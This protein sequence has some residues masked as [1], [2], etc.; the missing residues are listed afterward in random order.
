MAIQRTRFRKYSKYGAVLVEDWNSD[1]FHSISEWRRWRVLK[2]REEKDIISELRC[3]VEFCL[4]DD[5]IPEDDRHYYIADFV[6]YDRDGNM[7]VEDVKNPALA[8][9]TKWYK[10]NKE[11]LTRYGLKVRLIHPY[12]V[13]VV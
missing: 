2:D 12:R 4:S 3:Q 10:I 9:S 11:M 13:L 7:I 6:Y 1:C 5:N 8:N